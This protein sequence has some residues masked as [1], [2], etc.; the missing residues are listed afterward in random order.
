MPFI[1]LFSLGY[2]FTNNYTLDERG[3]V[4]VYVPEYGS[5]IFIDNELKKTTGTFQRELFVQ[6]LKPKSYTVIV[7]N[8]NFQ[9][10]AKNVDVKEREVSPLYPLLVPKKI[11]IKEIYATSTQEYKKVSDFF[12]PVKITAVIA[13]TTA[14]SSPE[15]LGL[16]KNKMKIWSDDN[17]VFAKWTG[18]DTRT[19]PYFCKDNVCE[20]SLTVFEAV[21]PIRH[22]DFYPDRDDAVI[23][24]V[25]D[26][27]YATEI[28][29]RSYH[30]FYTLYKGKNP[31]FRINN[32]KVYVKD[33]KF[34]AELID[35]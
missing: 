1:V 26:G 16:L 30:N 13:T 19:P 15:S 25:G 17:V 18:S 34:I 4:Y 28:D 31:D 5:E 9:P 32:G 24:S 7:S 2:R 12:A 33:G 21:S 29:T 3:G 35:L 10:W 8:E 14:T 11:D 27:V 22:V 6:N 23:I 20:D